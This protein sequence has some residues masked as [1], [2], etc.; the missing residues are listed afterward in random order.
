MTGNNKVW[1][2]PLAGLASVAMLATMGVAAGTANANPSTDPYALPSNTNFQV[3]VFRKDTPYK[4]E[5]A[6]TSSNYEYGD[7]FD[8]SKV[9]DPY[10]ADKTDG[11]ILTGYSYD[12]AGND[13]VADGKIAVKGDTKLY[14]QY[15]EAHTVNFDIDGDGTA[16]AQAEVQDGKSLDAAAYRG[17]G[18]E[19]LAVSAATS[20]GKVFA[21]WKTTTYKDFSKSD[22]YTNQAVNSDITLYPVFET[23]SSAQDEANVSV[24][25][26]K[27]ADNDPV[28]TSK[29][30]TF[31]D[32]PF[33]AYRVP[34]FSGVEQWSAD[35]NKTAYDFTKDVDND[36]NHT[37]NAA[38]LA[39]AGYSDFGDGNWT[40]T[41][42]YGH[43]NLATKF[44]TDD[45]DSSKAGAQLYVAEGSTIAEPN[46][47]A[48]WNAE[49]TGWYTDKDLKTKVDFSKPVENLGGSTG[50]RT[51]TVY[52]GWDE[53]NIAQVN[54]YYGYN[55][56]A[57]NV[58][59]ASVNGKV[60]AKTGAAVEF[61]TR[62]SG[63]KAPTGVEDY[64]QTA[65]DKDHGTYTSRTVKQ[66]LSVADDSAI[67]TVKA[68]T[69]VYAKWTGA[70]AILLD[71]NGGEFAN[72][73]KYIYVTKTDSQ[74]WNEVVETPTRSGYVLD[75]NKWYSADGQCYANLND[76]K[77]YWVSDSHANEPTGALLS[78]GVL[79]K[80]VAHWV[81]ASEQAIPA[82]LSAYPLN[83]AT[84]ASGWVPSF[85]NRQADYA[86]WARYAKSE[87]QW[88]SYVDYIYDSLKDE[89]QSYFQLTDAQ[90][91]YEAAEA[92]ASKLA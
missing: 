32:S 43:Y 83:G 58:P 88:K 67:E 74:K 3:R 75:S 22:L 10:A 2:A 70:Y 1:R 63:I 53:D 8:L 76:G 65:A 62:G 69:S 78:D 31:A 56:A 86:L 82:A 29:L 33:P 34:N 47:P 19:T 73:E 24:V 66:W 85:A 49:F 41:Y 6:T 16:D 7:T 15:A 92:L 21:G 30:Y 18:A 13:K 36:A 71:A 72:G 12:L 64:F 11:K 17:S 77:W 27:L 44:T 80:L 37:F 26:F 25:T 55:D 20:A 51:L 28:A 81:V 54:Y 60:A 45:L 4:A 52:A 79:D 5:A 9:S 89:Y 14:A 91:K 35:G 90:K 68:N 61:V 46:D 59:A 40:V 57:W 39:L 23:Y 50:A 48:Q 42:D 84:E 38:D 87:A